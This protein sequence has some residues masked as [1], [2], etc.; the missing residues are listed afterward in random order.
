MKLSSTL[1][2][3]F[4]RQTSQTS[5]RGRLNVGKKSCD[6]HWKVV[7]SRTKVARNI[8]QSKVQRERMPHEP[9]IKARS[10]VG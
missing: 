9:L 10:N 1:G 5:S 4:R 7:L 3:C 2:K 8:R 6:T